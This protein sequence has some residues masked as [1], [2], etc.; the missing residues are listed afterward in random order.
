MSLFSEDEPFHSV[1][2]VVFEGKAPNNGAVDALQRRCDLPL[3]ILLHLR[4]GQ[5]AAQGHEA[6]PSGVAAAVL[7][8]DPHETTVDSLVLVHVL[9]QGQVRNNQIH[10]AVRGWLGS[11]RHTQHLDHRRDAVVDDGLVGAVDNQSRKCVLSGAEVLRTV[12]HFRK[13]T[14]KHNSVACDACVCVLVCHVFHRALDELLAEGRDGL[15]EGV[16]ERRHHRQ[17]RNDGLRVLR[18]AAVLPQRRHETLQEGEEGGAVAP[19]EALEGF[20]DGVEE[21]EV[22]RLE[23]VG[24]VV[25]DLDLAE[26]CAGEQ[27]LHLRNMIVDVHVHRNGADRVAQQLDG[28][29]GTRHRCDAHVRAQDR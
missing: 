22:A 13:G 19:S 2:D 7:L 11:V 17:R 20:A 9:F 10:D 12:E 15:V 6:H 23:L 4:M 1:A 5:G 24:F 3:D 16:H 18:R 27:V 21:H 29:Q 14:E 25:A 28:V 26:A 8:D